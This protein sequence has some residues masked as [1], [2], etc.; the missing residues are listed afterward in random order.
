LDI[1]GGA[2]SSAGLPHLRLRPWGI[3]V[4]KGRQEGIEVFPKHDALKPGRYGN[5]IREPLGIHRG[6]AQRFWFA[7][8][9]EDLERQL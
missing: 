7:G 6:A 8:A 9:D 4:K 3:P 5:A 2:A 1:S